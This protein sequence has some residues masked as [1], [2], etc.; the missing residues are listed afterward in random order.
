MDQEENRGPEGRVLTDQG[1]L[2]CGKWGLGL[3]GTS[4][5]SGMHSRS[6]ACSCACVRRHLKL[7]IHLLEEDCYL[8]TR[9]INLP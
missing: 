5:C 4:A 6:G 7:F 9:W 3:K 8:S 2:I 1:S